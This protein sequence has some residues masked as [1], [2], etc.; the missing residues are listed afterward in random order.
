LQTTSLLYAK[1]CSAASPEVD[2]ELSVR[3]AALSEN[4]LKLAEQ[5]FG[6][7]VEQPI[8]VHMRGD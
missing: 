8:M 2:G 3:L 1:S 5:Y 6:E 4:E 7:V